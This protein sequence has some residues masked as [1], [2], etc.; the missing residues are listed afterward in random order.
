MH[1]HGQTTMNYAVYANIIYHFT[2]YVDWPEA[3]KSGDFI[4]GIVGDSPI[5]NELKKISV[6]KMAGTQ[7]IVVEKVPASLETFD[8]HILFISEDESTSLKKIVK[9]TEGK[10]VLLVSESEGAA[11]RGACINFTIVSERLT[12]EIN[13]SNIQQRKLNIASELLKLGVIVK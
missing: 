5:F 9:R 7:S 2:K 10:P 8:C 3:K 11:S 12:L 6:N 1:G 4:I 13:K